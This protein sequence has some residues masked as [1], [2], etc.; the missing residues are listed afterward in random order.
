MEE[1]ELKT[2]AFNGYLMNPVS[3]EDLRE[4][5]RNTLETR[6]AESGKSQ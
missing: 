1:E 3:V 2:H 6:K 5:V 4:L